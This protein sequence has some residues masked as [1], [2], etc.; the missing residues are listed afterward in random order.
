VTPRLRRHASRAAGRGL[1]AVFFGGRRMAALLDSAPS[2]VSRLGGSRRGKE[3]WKLG[4]CQ[5]P[6]LRRWEWAPTRRVRSPERRAGDA[7]G[8]RASR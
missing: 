2:R 3:G 7:C 6:S 5:A 4:G 8:G 1:I